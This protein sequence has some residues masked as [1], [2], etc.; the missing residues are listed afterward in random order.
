[1]QETS[2]PIRRT[3]RKGAHWRTRGFLISVWAY[4]VL[5]FAVLYVYVNFRSFVMA[6]QH[7]DPTTFEYTFAGFDNFRL[8]IDNL[9]N[10]ADMDYILG[11]SLIA[12][13]AKVLIDIPASILISFF[14][15]KKIYASGALKIALFLP[16]IISS[17]VWVTMFKYFVEWALPSVIEALGGDASDVQL[18]TRPSQQFGTMLFYTL[19]MGLPGSMLI[20][21]GTMTRI[22]SSLV[23]AGKLDGMGMMSELWHVVLPLSFPV[24]SVNIITAI[25]GFFTNQLSLYAFFEDGAEYQAYTFGYYLFALVIG[26]NQGG[27]EQYPYASA[28]GLLFTLIAAP[29]TLTVK[30]LLEKFGP[31]AEF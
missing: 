25:P 1:M 27:V 21:L 16:T 20:Y 31:E 9:M 13:L 14:L 11:N 28:A 7:V 2:L 5:L 8:F 17:I 30:W 23:E 6:F 12:F 19:W 10:L 4:P 15:Y 24:V 3:R 26:K 22:P 18:L 29:L